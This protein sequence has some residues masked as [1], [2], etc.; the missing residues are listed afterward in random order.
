M[1]KLKDIIPSLYYGEENNLIKF[2]DALDVEIAALE[3]QVKGITDFINVDKCPD[4]KLPYLAALTNCPLIGKDPV[5]WRKQIKNWA[6]ILKLKGTERSLALVLDSIGADTWDIKTFFR[7][8]GE[9]YTTTK[10]EGKPFRDNQGKW[11]NIR[12]HYFGIEFM[13]GKEFIERN[14]FSWDVDDIKEK[15]S[16]WLERGKPY[17]SELLSIVIVPPKFLPDGHICRWDFCEWEHTFHKDYNF[18]LLIP[19]NDIFENEIIFSRITETNSYVAGDWQAWDVLKWDGASYRLLEMGRNVHSDFS[20]VVDWDDVGNAALL[21]PLSW[22]YGKWDSAKRVHRYFVH[23][24]ESIFP[25][26]FEWEKQSLL[27]S[28]VFIGIEYS[29]RPYWDTHSWKEH[30][31]WAANIRQNPVHV[32][33]QRDCTASLEWNAKRENKKISW[34]VD[35]WD[36]LKAPAKYDAPLPTW[37]KHKTWKTSATWNITTEQTAT[38]EKGKWE[39]QEAI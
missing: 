6:Y 14:N 9:G 12:T 10:P 22:D 5:F 30:N 18:G 26:V 15:L 36:C 2:V 3:K 39:F 20:V 38:A 23:N 24:I 8:A 29:A 7:D 21:S 16:F 37:S 32:S 17:H 31:T 35:K 4:G 19:E 11:H 25:V 27:G 28:T 13:M 33:I 1:S 34:D